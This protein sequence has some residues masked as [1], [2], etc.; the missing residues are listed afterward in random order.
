M[1]QSEDS[2]TPS[3][4]KTLKEIVEGLESAK[5]K[6]DGVTIMDSKPSTQQLSQEE[7]EA[8]AGFAHKNCVFCNKTISSYEFIMCLKCCGAPGHISCIAELTKPVCPICKIPIPDNLYSICRRMARYIPD[9]E[10]DD[11]Q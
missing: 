1:N 3:A 5:K 7:T 6:S 8:D 11:E 10:G 2:D 9:S 4:T